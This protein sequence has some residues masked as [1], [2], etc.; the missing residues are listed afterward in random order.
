MPR[1]GIQGLEVLAAPHFNR[2]S[3]NDIYSLL[4]AIIRGFRRE[5]RKP[6]FLFVP[7]FMSLTALQSCL[8]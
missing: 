1:A 6:L 3:I 8:V 5:L 2:F 4:L 7:L